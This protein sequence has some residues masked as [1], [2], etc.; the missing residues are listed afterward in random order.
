MSGV[1]P[2]PPVQLLWWACINVGLPLSAIFLL[3]LACL[4]FK[5]RRTFLDVVKDGQLFLFSIGLSASTMYDLRQRSAGVAQAGLAISLL[6]A[7]MMF[8]IALVAN[9]SGWGGQNATRDLALTSAATL[10]I[11][12]LLVL[13]FR[14]R[15]GV[16]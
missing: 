2:S 10:T 6:F 12:V 16:F 3:M 7:L 14:W 11:S 9:V 5:V 15:T 1:T 8:A 4:W 13:W